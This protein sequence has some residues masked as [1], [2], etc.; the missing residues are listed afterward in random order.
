MWCVLK[1]AEQWIRIQMQIQICVYF[2]QQRCISS[3]ISQNWNGIRCVIVL[4]CACLHVFKYV[5]VWHTDAQT[6]GPRACRFRIITY[7]IWYLYRLFHDLYQSHR[8]DIEF[9]CD[10]MKIFHSKSY[11]EALV[12]KSLRYHQIMYDSLTKLLQTVDKKRELPPKFYVEMVKQ[13]SCAFITGGCYVKCVI[14][15]HAPWAYR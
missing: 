9:G 8:A 2:I 1:V 5:C 6:I 14:R 15:I 10:S 13:T 11:S 4:V 7:T 3:A 12:I